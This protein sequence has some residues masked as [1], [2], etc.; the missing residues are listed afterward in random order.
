MII[1]SRLLFE[2][3]INKVM[4]FRSEGFPSNVEY[5]KYRAEKDFGNLPGKQVDKCARP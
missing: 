3:T 2:I 1:V 5:I 4:F